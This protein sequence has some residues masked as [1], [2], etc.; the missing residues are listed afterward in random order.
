MAQNLQQSIQQV[1]ALNHQK[2]NLEN[3]IVMLEAELGR[4]EQERIMGAQQLARL[5]QQVQRAAKDRAEG[6][7]LG[8]AAVA[9]LASQT[10][11][12]LMAM[13]KVRESAE[14]DCGYSSESL[15]LLLDPTSTEGGSANG[16]RGLSG[17]EGLAL[18]AYGQRFVYTLRLER[19]KWYVGQTQSLAR[20]I[21]D[22]FVGTGS[23]WTE[24]YPPIEAVSTKQS[25]SEEEA[26]GL[27]IATTATLQVKYGFNNVRGGNIVYSY[28]IQPPLYW[29]APP[30]G[31]DC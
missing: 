18:A 3:Q 19:G 1:H 13:T 31:L 7:A 21:H 8:E 17:F 20:R 14:A 27:E 15:Q 10:Q 28:D 23:K 22:Q 11:A 30:H 29:K 12:A 9:A 4:V 6:A 16:G 26:N 2:T 25:K 5:E 24:K